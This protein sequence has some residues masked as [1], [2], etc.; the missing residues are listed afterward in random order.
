MKTEMSQEPGQDKEAN[1]A[2]QWGKCKEYGK[3]IGKFSMV[4][5]HN[6]TPYQ[7]KNTF[8]ASNRFIDKILFYK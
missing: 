5:L 3:I 6:F 8:S 7:N 4:T 2:L 1:A